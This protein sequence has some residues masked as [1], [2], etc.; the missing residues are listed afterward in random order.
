MRS[1]PQQPN[2]VNPHGRPLTSPDMLDCPH[3]GKF[4]VRLRRYGGHHDDILFDPVEAYETMG[5]QL[6][7]GYF[8]DIPKKA[9]VPHV[10]DQPPSGRAGLNHEKGGA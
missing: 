10:C 7:G 6:W 4:V 5:E 1:T 8:W 3:C 2:P 9:Y